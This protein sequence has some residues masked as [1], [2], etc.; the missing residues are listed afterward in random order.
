MALDEGGH[1][2]ERD[3]EKL[4]SALEGESESEFGI[5]GTDRPRQRPTDSEKQKEYYSGKKKRHTVKNNIIGGLNSGKVHYLGQ[6][7][8]GKKHD[9]KIADEESPTF[10]EGAVLFKDTG[11]QGYEPPGVETYQPK[12][13]PKG[14]ELT[15]R[16][17]ESNSLISA[18]RI[19]IEHIISGIKRCHIV[20]DIFRNT[21]EDFD[22][23]AM[24]IACALHNFR[25]ECR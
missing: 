1:L 5:D 2:P 16:E 25:V 4:G 24:L 12:K 21:K 17:K 20:K 22:D 8:E 10:P 15:A 18:I 7:H 19:V 14:G 13:K 9:K 3:P 23:L 6:T 11:F